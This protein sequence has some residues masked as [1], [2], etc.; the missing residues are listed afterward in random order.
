MVLAMQPWLAHGTALQP[1]TN[2][3]VIWIIQ[4]RYVS[5]WQ[6][7]CCMYTAVHFVHDQTG[8]QLV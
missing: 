6:L 3:K 8:M 2:V 5:H 4:Y 1:S 7:R